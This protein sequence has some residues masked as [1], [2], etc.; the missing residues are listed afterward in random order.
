MTAS[1]LFLLPALSITAAFERPPVVD[2]VQRRSETS[3]SRAAAE[4]QITINR[5][6]EARR[7]LERSQPALTIGVDGER[8]VLTRWVTAAA[9][10]KARKAARRG[11]VFTRDISVWLRRRIGLIL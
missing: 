9:L 1:I 8:I 7:R 6:V 4:F 3:D 5:Y 11:D 2:C 10:Q